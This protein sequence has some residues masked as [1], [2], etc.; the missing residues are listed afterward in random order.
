MRATTVRRGAA[1]RRVLVRPRLLLIAALVA[2]TGCGSNLPKTIRVSGRVTLDGQPPP[3]AGTIYFL[4]TAAAEGFPTRPATGDFDKD[5][6]FQ[7][8]TFDPGDGLL[9]GTYTMHIECWQ[10]P[11][12]MEGKPVKSYI[13]SK[14]QSAATS[15]LTL[16]I[17]PNMRA[18][19]V[20][21]DLASK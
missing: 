9:P 14:Y 12:N 10:T 20:N 7:A 19:T 16:E 4:P 13:P 1:G 5:G 2:A 17:K 11:P 21:F 6:N 8:K 18:Q 15:G 3:G